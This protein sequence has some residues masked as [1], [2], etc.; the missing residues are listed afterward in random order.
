MARRP[1]SVFRKQAGDMIA[2]SKFLS[3]M[4]GKAEAKLNEA[5]AALLE[6]LA[7]GALPPLA[8]PSLI[9]NRSRGTAEIVLFGLL[10]FPF[11]GEGV[12]A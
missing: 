5:V 7:T 9:V 8:D 6:D 3:M 12:H 1:A 4:D 2:A 11:G 10:R